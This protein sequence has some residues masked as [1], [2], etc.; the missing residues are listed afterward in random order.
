[1]RPPPER[2]ASRLPNTGSAS[3]YPCAEDIIARFVEFGKMGEKP[4]RGGSFRPPVLSLR[5]GAKPR[6]GNPSPRPQS[7]PPR[8]W[9]AIF[10]LTQGFPA[11]RRSPHPVPAGPPSPKGRLWDVG[12]ESFRHGLRPCHLPL[13]REAVGRGYCGCIRRRRAAEDSGPY[14]QGSSHSVGA[15][16]PIRPQCLPCTPP[17]GGTSG[18]LT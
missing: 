5:G 8:R 13:T 4:R 10:V 1:M 9:K 18:I 14:G 2:G 15:D 17:G 3:A 12:T 7:L 16:V 11:L 6:R